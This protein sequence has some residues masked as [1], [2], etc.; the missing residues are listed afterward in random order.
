M[1]AGTK[2]GEQMEYFQ[3][4]VSPVRQNYPAKLKNATSTVAV[5]GQ[6]VRMEQMSIRGGFLVRI[7]QLQADS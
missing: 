5:A 1:E 3:T 7:I 6:G 2:P 4:K